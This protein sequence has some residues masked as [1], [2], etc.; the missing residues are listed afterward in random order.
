[1][2]QHPVGEHAL[3]DLAHLPGAGDDAAAVD[4]RAQAV[5]GRGTPRS[6][7]RPPASS[8]RRASGRP[9][10]GKSSAMPA[11]ETPGT[12]CSARARSE[13]RSPRARRSRAP[14]PD[15][16]GWSRG[17]RRC[18]VAPRQFEAVVGADQVRLDEVVRA[19]VEAGHDRRL[20]RALDERV[21]LADCEQIIQ[22]RA[23][24][25][26]AKRTPAPR[27]RGRFSSEPRRLRLSS[28]EI[29]HSG[30]RV[31]R[32]MARLAPTKPAPPVIR[33][34]MAHEGRGHGRMRRQSTDGNWPTRDE[35]AV[36]EGRTGGAGA[37]RQRWSRCL[38]CGWRGVGRR[39]TATLAGERS[40][41]GA[42][43]GGARARIL[44]D[45]RPS[46]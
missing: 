30:W 31:T 16:R 10:S 36:T 2:G 21:D 40:E 32:P 28:T 6:A 41:H 34:L 12:V 27:R 14:A 35:A 42:S 37:S 38:G 7:A 5:R 20:G 13:S 26:G 33:T 43:R 25:R 8:R 24:R 11:V 9:S 45:R 18:A 39:L 19:A 1:M 15:R 46:R 44:R 23:R 17:R 29:S 3:V 4:H 22:A